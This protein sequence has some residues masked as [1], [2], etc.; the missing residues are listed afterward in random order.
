MFTRFMMLCATVLALA[1]GPATA[2]TYPGG[3][4]VLS[5]GRTVR[6]IGSKAPEDPIPYSKDIKTPQR[7]W[8][9]L[10]L[11]AIAKIDFLE[12]SD[13]EKAEMGPQNGKLPTSTRK[14]NV[15]M[16]S[17]TAYKGVFLIMGLMDWYNQDET[18]NFY[19]DRVKSVTFDPT[20]GAPKNTATSKQPKEVPKRYQDR[21]TSEDPVKLCTQIK[22]S[23]AAPAAPGG[24]L[25]GKD[26]GEMA[27]ILK[28]CVEL[29][30]QGRLAP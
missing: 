17:G 7:D 18:G 29:K 13:A 27:A 14:A 3:R 24:P 21:S 26:P 15:T 12:M 2:E 19:E 25:Y 11:P 5:D 23:T 10:R 1:A 4:I 28:K 6:F 22:N 30:Q 8:S 9:K 16:R 20:T